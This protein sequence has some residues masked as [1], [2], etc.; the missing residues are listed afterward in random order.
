MLRLHHVGSAGFSDFRYISSS[1]YLVDRRVYPACI[2]WQM[3]EESFAGPGVSHR[4]PETL[5]IALEKDDLSALQ[6]FPV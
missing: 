4:T 5:E 1:T 3:Y 6:D 2:R